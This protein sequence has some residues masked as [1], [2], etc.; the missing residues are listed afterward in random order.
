MALLRDPAEGEELSYGL[1]T[2]TIRYSFPPQISLRQDAVP[3]GSRAVLTP[4]EQ[5]SEKK[6][7]SPPTVHLVFLDALY[8]IFPLH[9]FPVTLFRVE[10]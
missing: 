4:L 5:R 1:Y 3:K 9:V 7:I 10:R 8:S 2:D 6:R